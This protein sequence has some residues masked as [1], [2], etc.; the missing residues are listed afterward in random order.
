[1]HIYLSIYFVFFISLQPPVVICTMGREHYKKQQEYDK[2]RAHT[3]FSFPYPSM[4]HRVLRVS[5]TS[6]AVRPAILAEWMAS[7]R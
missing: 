3:L 4:S 5:Q 7:V 6:S 2:A 1:M